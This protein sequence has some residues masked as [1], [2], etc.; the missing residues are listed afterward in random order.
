[1]IVQ[2]REMEQ[3]SRFA[4]TPIVSATFFRGEAPVAVIRSRVGEILL[5]NPW[6]AGH[7]EHVNFA[8][9]STPVNLHVPDVNNINIDD[10]V[11][12]A[13]SDT[14]SFSSI[15]D[16]KT[17]FDKVHSELPHICKELPRRRL[18]AEKSRLFNITI[19]V[20]ASSTSND[21]LEFALI[22]S[23]SHI[24]ADGHTY[25]AVFM[26]IDPTRP[27]V[28]MDPVRA[29]KI[30]QPALE[31]APDALVVLNS[32]SFWLRF[33]VS[34]AIHFV[35]SL[36]VRGRGIQSVPQFRRVNAEFICEQKKLYKEQQ[37]ASPVSTNDVIASWFLRAANAT[38]GSVTV[39]L[40]GRVRSLG[41]LLAGN[42]STSILFEAA[43]VVTPALIRKAFS[44]P[45]YLRRRGLGP[46]APLIKV[47]WFRRF[48]Y[49]L[50]TNVSTLYEEIRFENC[51]LLFNLPL[52]KW[53]TPNN[54]K[55]CFVFYYKKNEIGIMTNDEDAVAA[56]DGS[57][58]E[59]LEL[60][61][62]IK[63]AVL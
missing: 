24:I 30:L 19:A 8:D 31:L 48:S 6:L 44:S 20:P 33:A 38:L 49:A 34:T 57:V 23:M 4:A 16:P 46:D 43:D 61:S 37:P 51:E 55:L 5:A 3:R 53:S 26:M 29:V 15:D 62:E 17:I 27:I 28:A 9:T 10:Y 52:M 36:V 45:P 35:W 12:V 60:N 7:L 40:R 54:L 42:Y 58:L 50:V 63:I 14:I 21:A 25:G 39:N 18:A 1:M 41:S 32:V 13:A 56:Y 11:T 22:M 47:P 2:L 59:P